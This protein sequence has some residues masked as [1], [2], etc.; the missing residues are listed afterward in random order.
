MSLIRLLATLKA[1]WLSMVVVTMLGLIATVI[2]IVIRPV[3]YMATASIVL[4]AKNDPVSS[5]LYGGAVSPSMIN[6]QLEV[7]RSERVAQRVVK[8]MKLAEMADMKSKWTE[9]TDGSGSFESW[10]AE[11]LTRGLLIKLSAPGSTVIEV[12]YQGTEPR[13]AAAMANAFVQAYMETSI[14][15]RIDPALQYNSFFE[16]Q[17]RDSREALEAAQQRLSKFQQDKGLLVADGRFDIETSR[18]ASL[19][20]A[21]VTLQAQSISSKG[22][23][24]Q[25]SRDADRMTEVLASGQVNSLKTELVRAEGRLAELNARYGENHP[26][27]ADAKAAVADLKQRLAVETRNVTGSINAEARVSTNKE[28]EL[29]AA[30]EAQRLK[31]L[32]MKEVRDQGEVLARDVEN[33]K[34]TYDMLFTRYNQTNI[35]SQNRLSSATVL[36]QAETP[37]RPSSRPAWMV[38]VGGFV[39]SVFAALGTALIMEQLDP[40]ARTAEDTALSVGLPVIGVM[41]RPNVT[42][43]A[44]RKLALLQQRVISGRQLPPPT[45]P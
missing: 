39:M 40:R 21:L 25:A 27:V 33:A 13:F 22:R 4:D 5:M 7:L 10:L 29:R 12:S 45:K 41:P 15:L 43:L 24:A 16:G 37:S 11:S 26:M 6:T 35:E 14:E 19:S 36:S 32:Q 9:S 2:F 3:A 34:R 38:L 31:V 8:N 23:Q 28:E 42:K 17:V 30:L 18:L 44:K 1:R 20:D